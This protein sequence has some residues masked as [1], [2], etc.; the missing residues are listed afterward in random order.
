M[1]YSFPIINT[2]NDVL[3]AI[4]GYDEF[5]VAERDGYRVIN[6][7]VNMPHTFDMSG[8]DD[9]MGALRRE[10]RGIIFYPDGRLMSRPFHKFFNVNEREETLSE[11]IDLRKPHHVLEKMD[12]SMIRPLIVNGELRLGT[13]MGVTDIALAAHLLLTENQA[14]LLRL[15]VER[16][17]FTPLFEYIAPSNKI[18]INYEDAKLVYLGSRDNVDGGYFFDPTIMDEFETVPVH[19]VNAENMDAFVQVAREKIGREGDVIRFTDGHMLKIKNDWYVRLHKLLDKVRNKRNMIELAFNNELDDALPMLPEEERQE[20]LNT[21]E[22]FWNAME[23]K[24]QNLRD[25]VDRAQSEFG[26]DPKRVALE[27]VPHLK[28]KEDARYIFRALKGDSI[29]DM[30]VEKAKQLASSSNIKFEEFSNWLEGN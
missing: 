8:P 29:R 23:W 27:M 4:E 11:K 15:N 9:V 14:K 10:C 7:M 24:I 12:G 2:I 19:K 22:Y 17:Q 16:F 1:N 20:V 6:Y 5:I 25:L 3:P 13:K 30:L 28:S 21:V 26:G 18:V